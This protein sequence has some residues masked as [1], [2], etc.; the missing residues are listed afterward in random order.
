MK[1]NNEQFID[2][3]RN[4]N[5]S[6][7][8]EDRDIKEKKRLI[9]IFDSIKKDLE[10][11]DKATLNN[12]FLKYI[13]KEEKSLE[14]KK[15][16]MYIKN[17]IFYF[18]L[19]IICIINLIGIYIII[20]IYNTVKSFFLTSLLYYIGY[21]EKIPNYNFYDFLFNKSLNEP[22]D[23]SLI[24]TMNIF[25]QICLN[26]CKFRL[27]SFVFLILNSLILLLIY[28][29]D[30]MNYD[31]E[32]YDYDFFKLLILFL[33]C[34]LMFIMVGSS[35]I[36]SQQ[37]LIDNIIKFDK[38]KKKEK[39]RKKDYSIEFED[40]DSQDQSF[41]SNNMDN[42]NNKNIN[43][44]SLDSTNSI[45]SSSSNQIN[46]KE[47]NLE[48]DEELIKKIENVINEMKKLRMDKNFKNE[49]NQRKYT[50]QKKDLKYYLNEKKEKAGQD[51]LCSFI[52]V[53][54]T[55]VLGYAFK[56]LI[57]N[58]YL[59]N[60]KYNYE[61]ELNKN[62]TM[63]K[64]QYD[65]NTSFNN[66]TPLLINNY[67]ND[68]IFKEQKYFHDKKLFYY[69]CLI[70]FS[71]ILLSI[72]LYWIF[73]FIFIKKEKKKKKENENSVT[74]YKA[75]GC[76]C[77]CEKIPTEDSASNNHQCC[78]KCFK[79]GLKSIKNFCDETIC[80]ACFCFCCNNK[81]KCPC[82]CFEYNENDYDKNHECFCYIY[83]E[84]MF[85]YWLNRY[86][87]NE[88]QKEIIPYLIEYFF[89]KLETIAFEEEYKNMKKDKY[90]DYEDNKTFFICFFGTFIYYIFFAY[91]MGK[92]IKKFKK[93]KK[94]AQNYQQKKMNFIQKICFN[95]HEILFGIHIVFFSNSILSLLISSFLLL[96]KLD[97]I[98]FEKDTLAKEIYSII[99]MNRHFFFTLNYYISA[100]SLKK[101]DLDLI[102]ASI[103]ISIYISII[104]K[105]ISNITSKI[106]SIN[107]LYIIQ[108]IVSTIPSLFFVII[109]IWVFLRYYCGFFNYENIDTL[110]CICINGT[111]FCNCCCCDIY[112][113]FY[114][115][116]CDENC[117]DCNCNKICCCEF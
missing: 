3:D 69:I 106:A 101:K 65:K 8:G 73:R 105:I 81:M 102:S 43:N 96:G 109:I 20:L 67:T 68:T 89:L 54:I 66:I 50:L 91:F 34:F 92:V 33:F 24:F 36:L 40:I 19:P 117:S 114:C 46:V 61:N 88:M 42:F 48:K 79:L 32:T 29:Y 31:K 82:C 55:T 64:T 84:K 74:I 2:S 11:N 100:S 10:E 47:N 1:E 14:I 59:S 39:E 76:V 30:F 108:I 70:Y 116:Y 80:N 16:N 95:A 17:L 35:S 94:D 112:S 6:L 98:L 56:Y 38:H 87:T 71:C 4:E 78:S 93:Y 62:N 104:D 103:L 63:N 28:N 113:C 110:P 45:N 107:S 58:I 111:C 44:N 15:I 23:F 12:I 77:F 85:C 83:R 13:E 86:L 18:C 60:I 75:L 27:T 22:I 7:I 72:I 52:I 41:S 37:R 9:K 51:N 5:Q 26:S 90:F 115:D 57:I 97:L 25:G 53:S 49:E 21:D 99:S